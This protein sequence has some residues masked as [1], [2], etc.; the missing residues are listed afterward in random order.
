MQNSGKCKTLAKTLRLLVRPQSPPACLRKKKWCPRPDLNRNPRFRKPLLYPV[1]LR[2]RMYY[3][4]DL[5]SIKILRFSSF[6]VNCI[7]HLLRPSARNLLH[8]RRCARR[9]LLGPLLPPLSTRRHRGLRDHA[10]SPMTHDVPSRYVLPFGLLAL[11][12]V[13]IPN[14][15][16]VESSGPEGR[17]CLQ[18]IQD[19]KIARKQAPTSKPLELI[20][21]ATLN[22]MVRPRSWSMVRRWRRGLG[23]AIRRAGRGTYGQCARSPCGRNRGG[24]DGLVEGIAAFAEARRDRHGVGRWEGSHVGT[25]RERRR[26]RTGS[27]SLSRS[28]SFLFRQGLPTG[29]NDEETEGRER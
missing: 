8:A 2:E 27:K 16:Q 5:Q 29:E 9:L 20:L 23:R 15:F 6:R 1:E 14:R 17:A 24:I 28:C 11:R 3:L 12:T 7:V 22:A 25:R 13:L 10:R 21:N 18:A 19:V 4:R 26:S